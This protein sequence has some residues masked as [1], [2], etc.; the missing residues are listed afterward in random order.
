MDHAEMKAAYKRA[1][2]DESITDGHITDLQIE[3][4]LLRQQIEDMRKHIQTLESEREQW[5]RQAMGNG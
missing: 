5:Q 1:I 2:M 4:A 3:I